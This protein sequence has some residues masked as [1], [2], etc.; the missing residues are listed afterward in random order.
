VVKMSQDAHAYLD[1][2]PKF[3]WCARASRL[4]TSPVPS[5]GQQDPSRIMNRSKRQFCGG[6]RIEPFAHQICV[7]RKVS[8]E[9]SVGTVPSLCH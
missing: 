9:P 1:S 2:R 8:A 3:T 6:D 7:R 4:N 5:F